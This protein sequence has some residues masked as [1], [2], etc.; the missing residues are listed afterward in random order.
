MWQPSFF[1]CVGVVQSVTITSDVLGNR[2]GKKTIMTKKHNLILLLSLLLVFLV[3]A[4]GGSPENPQGNYNL[5]EKMA[6]ANLDIAG[7]SN[8]AIG[9]ISTSSRDASDSTRPYLAKSSDGV[10]FSEVEIKLDKTDYYVSEGMIGAEVYKLN[11]IGDYSIV[12][13][14]SSKIR[15]DLKPTPYEYII[16]E[17]VFQLYV[18]DS[19]RFYS[20]N[21]NSSEDK[22][23]DITGGTPLDFNSTGFFYNDFIKTYLVDN[24]TG[25]VYSMSSL[26]AFDIVNGIIAVRTGNYKSTYS[27]YSASIV[28]GN[29]VLKELVSNPDIVVYNVVKDE[30]GW[31]YV[32]NNHV[33]EKDETNKVYY[34]NWKDVVYC[35]DS[36]NNLFSCGTIN[37][38]LYHYPQYRFEGG[39]RIPVDY[40]TDCFHGF[41]SDSY[42]NENHIIEFCAKYKNFLIKDGTRGSNS[43]ALNRPDQ[44]FTPVEYDLDH[45]VNNYFLDNE[46]SILCA[47]SGN[48]LRWQKIDWDNDVVGNEI[49]VNLS[50]P[51][52]SNVD[53]MLTCY[54]MEG[55][56]IVAIENAFKCVE[57]SGTTFYALNW[58]DETSTLEKSVINQK[59]TLD[60][61]IVVEP[62]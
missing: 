60:N 8:L 27:F 39:E 51:I 32:L 7:A 53:E 22:L 38:T 29:L 41:R 15:E 11:T 12:S 55:A 20:K 21:Y 40:T 62:L 13:F 37:E 25:N 46:G 45:N 16:G 52:L 9:V 28:D 61:V 14:I 26:P 2:V 23:Y 24:S 1:C 54:Q 49:E 19:L 4:C 34:L 59:V 48:E 50:E 58:N 42:S 17:Q 47:L 57:L 36:D 6:K 10:S 5:E 56:Y 3:V 44:G 31:I 43:I 33:E 30:T 18:Y 35:T